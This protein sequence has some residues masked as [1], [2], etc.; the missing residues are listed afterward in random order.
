MIK[1]LVIDD[2]KVICDSLRDILELAGYTV[3]TETDPVKGLEVVKNKKPD[4]I[5][6]DVKM[7]KIGGA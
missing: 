6:L 2:K 3:F 5:L 1:V 4:C 7:P